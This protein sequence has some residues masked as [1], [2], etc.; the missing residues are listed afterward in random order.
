MVKRKTDGKKTVKKERIN[1]EITVE[2]VIVRLKSIIK[3]YSN[4][5]DLQL[6]LFDF[7]G[8]EFNDVVEYY[9]F[10]IDNQHNKYKDKKIN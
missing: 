2:N 7:G 1:E 9:K 4:G 6:F 8:N 5:N 3:E 10:K